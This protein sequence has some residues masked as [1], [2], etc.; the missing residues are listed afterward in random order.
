MG[1]FEKV[2]AFRLAHFWNHLLESDGAR[3]GHFEW[4]SWRRL[5]MIVPSVGVVS[6]AT[7]LP[8]KPGV[9]LFGTFHG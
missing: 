6:A 8:G 4:R 7:S 1:S 3:L 5:I 9:G 2:P